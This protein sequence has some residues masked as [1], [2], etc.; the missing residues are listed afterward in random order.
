MTIFKADYMTAYFIG[1]GMSGMV[2]SLV[3]LGQGSGSVS[4][5]NVSSTNATTNI[6]T[7]NVYPKS[8][9]PSF[10]VR[11]FLL[12]LFAMVFSSGIAFTLLNYCPYYREEYATDSEEEDLSRDNKYRNYEMS[13]GEHAR[14]V[15]FSD[16]ATID[17][18]KS[19]LLKNG[20]TFHTVNIKKSF[21]SEKDKTGH[22]MSKT[23][24]VYFLIMTAFLNA[25]SNC[26]LPSIQTFSCLPYGI[27]AYHLTAVLYNIANPVA[28]FIVVFRSAAS[29]GVITILSFLGSLVAGIILYTAVASPTPLL[30]G[31]KT[32]EALIVTVW[33][34]GGLL[35]TYSKVSIA[36]IFRPLGS[37][38]LMWIGVMQQVGSFLGAVLFYLIINVWS[39]FES[40]PFCP[41]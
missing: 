32:G 39:L 34:F 31:T 26:V 14:E 20:K 4:C 28:C 13:G 7:Y 11:D 25:L 30:V 24:Y 18:S 17:M 8:N 12:F 40:A 29:C 6:T 22:S 33:V 23:R 9:P 41:V 27:S 35:L 21:D 36:T 19:P 38:A 10:P 15:A 3:A 1:E 37:R 16:Q 2:P 5:V